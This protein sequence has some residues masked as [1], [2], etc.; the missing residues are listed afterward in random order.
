MMAA[1][2]L[3]VCPFRECALPHTWS[4]RAGVSAL[5]AHIRAFSQHPTR[6]PAPVLGA[7][8]ASGGGHEARVTD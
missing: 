8:E 4:V 5:T 7:P 2:Q 3:G 1:Y 6:L